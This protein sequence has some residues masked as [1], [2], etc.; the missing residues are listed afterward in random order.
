[1]HMDVQVSREGRT[2]EATSR[3]DQIFIAPAVG[4]C[5]SMWAQDSPLTSES[6]SAIHQVLPE[7]TLFVLVAHRPDLI[8]L[9][10]AMSLVHPCTPLIH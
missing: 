3:P 6:P 9:I 7:L 8:S 10:R 2:P 5:F 1:M 4:R